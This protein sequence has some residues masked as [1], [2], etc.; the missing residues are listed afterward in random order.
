MSEQDSKQAV[1]RRRVVGGVPKW[2]FD[3]GGLFMECFGDQ[4]HGNIT[5]GNAAK[6]YSAGGRGWPTHS[7][8]DCPEY[9]ESQQADSTADVLTAEADENA[10]LLGMSGEREAR[11]LAEIAEGKRHLAQLAAHLADVTAGKLAE[12]LARIEANAK[13]VEGESNG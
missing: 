2:G 13:R 10:R 3:C 5:A 4:R 1:V 6:L 7:I 12:T 9:V 8:V 11:H